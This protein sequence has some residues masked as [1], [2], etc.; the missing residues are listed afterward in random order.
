MSK[1]EG[2]VHDLDEATYHA[3]GALSSTEARML[4]RTPAEY[5]WKKDN[6][7]LIEPSAKF[8]IGSAVHS[9][10]LGTGYEIVEVEADN[11]MSKAAKEAREQA[12]AEGKV[13][14][15]TKE[16][17]PI[18]AAAE[19]VLAH[20]GAR[21]LFSQPG[22]AEVSV[23]ATDL[24]T[25]VDVRGRFDFLPTDFTLGA[26]SRVAVDLKTTRDASPRG[27]T[28][29]I[30]D[31]GYDIQRAWYLDALHRI[32]GED[33]EFV[34]VAVEKEPPYL[35]AVHQL[36]TIWAEMGVTKARKARQVYAEC[37]ASGEW[38]GYGN[39]VFLLSP[40]TWLIYQHEEEYGDE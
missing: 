36:P 18:D 7:P 19:A 9:K 10:V 23:F 39:E 13:A 32:T 30:A 15:L 29:S 16:L 21:Q 14:L 6:P 4:L 20:P 5:R 37:M 2:I 40:P 1:L 35:V 8:D 17:G 27:F 11:W 34:F 26:P 22:D 12:R 25:G 24:E 28:R 3:H 38:P 33:A 31:F